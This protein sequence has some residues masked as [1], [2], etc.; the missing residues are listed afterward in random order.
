MAL[1]ID[2]WDSY[3]NHMS[4]EEKISEKKKYLHLV[5][6]GKLP[7]KIEAAG[8]SHYNRSEVLRVQ[9][10]RVI[11]SLHI[12]GFYFCVIGDTTNNVIFLTSSSSFV[13]TQSVI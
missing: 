7:Y 10:T 3:E 13:L 9:K 6:E 11:V 4:I 8:K 12:T 2:P 5:K 1:R